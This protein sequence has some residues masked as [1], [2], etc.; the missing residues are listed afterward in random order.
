MNSGP[1]CTLPSSVTEKDSLAITVP[2]GMLTFSS[3]NF[4][5][6]S[7][8]TSLIR[9]SRKRPPWNPGLA[10]RVLAEVQPR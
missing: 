1:F 8:P 4:R 10:G 7:A 3:A 6:A 5:Y 9:V 2:A